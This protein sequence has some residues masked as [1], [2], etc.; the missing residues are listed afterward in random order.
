MVHA[1]LDLENA[2]NS[3][4]QKE[5]EFV[6]R[7]AA[8]DQDFE[9]SKETLLVYCDYVGARHAEVI[10][11]LEERHAKEM[12]VIKE[13]M[14]TLSSSVAEDKFKNEAK[15]FAYQHQIEKVK[16]ELLDTE[17]KLEKVRGELDWSIQKEKRLEEAL[18]HA[19][20]EIAIR[21]EEA[22]KWEFRAGEQLQQISELE[23]VRQ[24]L[25]SQLHMLRQTL[26]P[27][28]EALLKVN[29]KL[30][31][32][33]RE[34]ENVLN[35]I[36][37]KQYELNVQGEKIHLLQK[38]LRD[39][40]GNLLNKDAVLRRTAKLFDAYKHALQQ[41]YFDR[42]KMAVSRSSAAAGSIDN[43]PEISDENTY[44]G[45][46]TLL[47]TSEKKGKKEETIEIIAKNQGMLEAM[48]RLEL[49]LAA[50]KKDDVHTEIHVSE[51]DA[52]LE[53]QQRHIQL[54]HRNLS[55]TKASNLLCLS[56]CNCTESINILENTSYL[57]SLAV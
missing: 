36:S 43:S 27:K 57:S 54:M 7:N 1:R 3:A 50:Y 52:V 47:G 10:A 21:A 53:E 25:T 33:E 12:E 56:R 15:E 31:E 24:V 4:L 11:I 37:E 55:A 16:E 45:G 22:G 48:A 23:R 49:I 44:S 14:K 5:G 17:M 34:Y 32:G 28:Q 19:S 13:N 40:R 20:S 18:V 9:K 35:S 38:Q 41:A 6:E 26:G 29:E 46:N 42:K 2:K 30:Q 8:L 51:K 39:L